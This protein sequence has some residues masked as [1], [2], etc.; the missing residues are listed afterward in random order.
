MRPMGKIYNNRPIQG[1]GGRAAA[2][3]DYVVKK[4]GE[5]P[6]SIKYNNDPYR[7]RSYWVVALA[8]KTVTIDSRDIP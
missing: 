7:A 3:W 1:P 4:H 2:T 8:N 6:L 5:A